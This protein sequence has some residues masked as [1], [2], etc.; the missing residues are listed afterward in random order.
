VDVVCSI[1]EHGR[2]V[3][4][5]AAV[6]KV[7]GYQVDE[8]LGKEMLSIVNEC[9]REICSKSIRDLFNG[10]PAQSFEIICVTKDG[11]QLDSRWSLKADPSMQSLICMVHDITEQKNVER[12]RAEHLAAIT[13]NFSTPLATISQL[14]ESLGNKKN[15]RLSI[16]GAK[17]VEAA[18]V[19]SKRMLALINDLR[20]IEKI[21]TNS[22]SLILAPCFLLSILEHARK[23]VSPIAQARKIAINILPA[24]FIVDASSERLEQVF[25]NL[26]SNALKF[27]NENDEITVESQLSENDSSKLEVQV[28]DRGCGMRQDVCSDIFEPYFQIISAT[29]PRLGSTGLG[30]AICKAIIE[31][32]SGSIIAR[33]EVGAGSSFIVTLPVSTKKIASREML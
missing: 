29:R 13:K 10:S 24:D 19:S 30:L 1:D 9:D 4:V 14:L 22:E 32:H 20:D 23:S 15:C 2:F 5:S 26:L 27:S 28:I 6:S 7:L 17:L 25:V 18:N 21:K 16:E 33:S 11:R 3:A 31:K 12:M 8:L